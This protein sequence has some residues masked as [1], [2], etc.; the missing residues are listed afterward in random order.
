MAKVSEKNQNVRVLQ[1]INACNTQTANSTEYMIS[2][3]ILESVL[4]QEKMTLQGLA[5]R[6]AISPAAISRYIRKM[7]YASFEDFKMNFDSSLY[8]IRLYRQLHYMQQY[9]HLSCRQM[10]DHIYEDALANLKATYEQLDLEKIKALIQKMKQSNSVMILG[11]DHTLSDFYTF[12]LDL[13]FWGI[14][15]YL[16]KQHEIQKMQADRMDDKSIVLYLNV[17]EDF[18]MPQDWDILRHMHQKGAFLT[19]IF[20]ENNEKISALFDE[21]FLYGVPHS[22]NSGFQSLFFL[23]QIFSEILMA[24]CM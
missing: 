6:A 9:H 10:A 7:G 19:G 14:P 13:L 23:S 16:Y 17:C 24:S 15:A 2:H 11:D 1:F 3:A 4:N 18:I 21:I 8:Q 12:Q 22:V 5:E 20:Q